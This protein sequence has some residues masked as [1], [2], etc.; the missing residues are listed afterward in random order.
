MKITFLLWGGAIGGTERL[1]LTLAGEMRSRGLNTSVVFVA[2]E[3]KLG[4][5]LTRESL[6]FRCV[7][8]SP[9]RLVLRHPRIL[10]RAV[11]KTGADVVIV[12][13]FG[14]LG[15]ALKS[16]GFR[17]A[18]IGV[19]H[20]ALLTVPSLSPA[21]RL[22]RRTDRLIGARSHDA[23][24]AVSQFMMNLAQATHHARQLVCI[25]HGVRVPD[26]PSVLPSISDYLRVGYVGRLIPGKG[27][28]VTLHSLAQLRTRQTGILPKLMIAGD[29]PDRP[30]LET[31]TRELDLA[32][33]VE[34]I[35]WTDDVAGFWKA[36]HIS[37]VPS[38]EFVES[39]CMT[40]V[41]AMAH[42]RPSIVSNRGALPELVVPDLTGL[43][44][45]AGDTSSMAGAI[46][47]YARS[48]ELIA[49]HGM[50]AHERAKR[51]FTLE[52]C[53]DAYLALAEKIVSGSPPRGSLSAPSDN[54]PLGAVR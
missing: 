53:T 26:R 12:G 41:E 8:L 15:A 38:N 16:G 22:V 2:D 35:G 33:Q 18:V 9:G 11:A 29:G 48:P 36:Q 24:V 45:Q 23:E 37:V 6:D 1:S 10:A 19:E 21:K 52:R 31:L 20:G 5:H 17:G 49:T 46:A 39:F 44:V 3:G 7:N 13:S 32:G 34:F 54:A 4:K 27:V 50:A 28:D 40:A 14:F 47:R 42:G 43:L 30:A 25:K 51:G